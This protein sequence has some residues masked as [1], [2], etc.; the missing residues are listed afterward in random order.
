MS[1]EAGVLLLEE[2]LGVTV[3]WVKGHGGCATEPCVRASILRL[4]ASCWAWLQDCPG[5]NAMHQV[6]CALPGQAAQW[7]AVVHLFA[8][9]VLYQ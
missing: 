9:C 5:F 4:R 2:V 7:A 8:A 3:S 6:A 1:G